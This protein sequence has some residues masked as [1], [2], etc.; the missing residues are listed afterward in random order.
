V[1]SVDLQAFLSGYLAEV[2]EHLSSAGKHLLTVERALEKG[3]TSPREVRELYRQLHTIKGLS[4]MVG[5][6]PVVELAHAMESALRIADRSGGRLSAKTTDLLLLGLRA[7]EERVRALANQAPV[8]AAPRQ[9]LDELTAAGEAGPSPPAQAAVPSLPPQLAEKLGP[10]ELAEIQK[11]LSQGRRVAQV[12]FIPTPARAAQGLNITAV[13]ERL[14]AVA[15]LVK[16]LPISM[17]RSHDAPGGLAFWIVLVSDGSNALLAEAAG[18]DPAAVTTVAEAAET[19]A[20]EPWEPPIYESEGPARG[21]VVRVEVTRLDDALE[22]LSAL[23][24]SRF[25]MARA[26][27]DLQERG[28]DVRALQEIARESGRRLRDLRG[29]IMRARMVSVTELLDRVPLIIRGLARSTGKS[30]RLELDA[31]RAELDKAVGERIF[32]AI[33]HLIRNAI[34]H[35]IEPA[36]ERERLGKPR[37]GV[38]RVVAHERS[39]NQLELAISDDGRGIDRKRVAELAGR[40]LPKNDDELLALITRPGL[41][42]REHADTNSGRGMGMDIVR[43]IAVSDLGGEL[44]VA[45]EAGQGTR[46]VLRLPLSITIIDA[47]SFACSAQSFLVPVSTVDEILEIE[48]ARLV[49]PPALKNGVRSM[50]LERRGEALPLIQLR[51]CFALPASEG[52]RQKA[53]VVRKNGRPWA[54]A[55]DRM[56]GQQEV[57]VRPFE[58]PLVQVTG[59]TGS[60]DLGDGKPTL[61][62]DLVALTNT[63]AREAA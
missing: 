16:V 62:L 47:F 20:D 63:F 57:V 11:A 37:E 21:R 42:T 41:S 14:G 7:V 24:V 13:R 48:T 1:S 43:R 19:R 6:E 3:E 50:L 31:G 39:N 44:T 53:L 15:E 38:I 8:P 56:L 5:V 45:S 60:A 17:P 32:P 61:V 58:D 25:Q 23:V 49:Q 35:A 27:A 9:L 36:E 30:V 40:P 2:E 29:A 51:D 54:F 22:K 12:E 55:V 34:D 4:A 59:V 26:I 28:A 33:V 46:F 52:A 18:V 10:A